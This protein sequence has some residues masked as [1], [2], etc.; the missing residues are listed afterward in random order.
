MNLRICRQSI[1]QHVS[2]DVADETNAAL[3]HTVYSLVEHGEGA[4]VKDGLPIAGPEGGCFVCS[5]CADSGSSQSS[6]E[7]SELFQGKKTR[8]SPDAH[9]VAGMTAVKFFG[10]PLVDDELGLGMVC[11]PVSLY[12]A[13]EG[14]TGK[15]G[16]GDD[17]A[18]A[19][20]VVLLRGVVEGHG[21]SSCEDVMRAVFKAIVVGTVRL[22]TLIVAGSCEA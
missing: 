5:I 10:G 8:L 4:R 14:K 13:G 18:L 9:C 21:V 15:A 2:Q 6:V 22:Y 17:D 11:R 1:Q 16:A 19:G 12:G 7:K 3:R 20:E